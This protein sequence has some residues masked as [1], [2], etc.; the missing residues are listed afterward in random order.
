MRRR[1]NSSAHFC[2]FD[3]NKNIGRYC[4]VGIIYL[5]INLK[6]TKF[7]SNKPFIAYKSLSFLYIYILLGWII[8]IL[9]EKITLLAEIVLFV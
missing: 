1:N 9:C 3:I 8:D 7:A 5:I 6:Q 4:F 2:I